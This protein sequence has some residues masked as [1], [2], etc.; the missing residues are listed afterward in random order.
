MIQDRDIFWKIVVALNNKIWKYRSGK[1]TDLQ[2][3]KYLI[4]NTNL[5][6]FEINSVMKDIKDFKGPGSFSPMS[7]IYGH[8]LVR[9]GQERIET[10]NPDYDNVRKKRDE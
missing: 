6:L 1:W 9:N 5:N 2:M 7:I 3:R 10:D 8:Q 4:K